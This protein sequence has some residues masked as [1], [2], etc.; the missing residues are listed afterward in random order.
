MIPLA[1][2]PNKKVTNPAVTADPG[3]VPPAPAHTGPTTADIMASHASKLG[4]MAPPQSVP[5]SATTGGTGAGVKRGVPM[6]WA[7][8]NPIRVNAPSA[9]SQP[10]GQSPQPSTGLQGVI[11]SSVAQ[12]PNAAQNSI[13]TRAVDPKETVAGQLETLLKADSP[14][15][16]RAQALAAEQANSRGLMNSTLA[17]SAGTAAAIDAALRVA[18]PDAATFNEAGRYNTDIQNTYLRESLAHQRGQSNMQLANALQQDSL[19]LSAQLDSDS[20]E[21]LMAISQNYSQLISGSTAASQ[22]VQQMN[23][24]IAQ[25]LASPDIAQENKQGLINKVIESTRASLTILGVINGID[26]GALLDFG[27]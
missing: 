1:Y 27:G 22:S 12:M 23:Q 13:Y 3:D 2:L 26:F 4:V 5:M 17:S 11:G 24:N 20:R 15:L 8:E 19:R 18:Q 14:Y 7:A 10:A 25:I 16:Q 6:A 9:V 21:R